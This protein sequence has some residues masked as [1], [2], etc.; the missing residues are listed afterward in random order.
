[1]AR[2]DDLNVPPPSIP[3][4]WTDDNTILEGNG[5][6]SSLNST[7]THPNAITTSSPIASL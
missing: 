4:L 6:S 3:E 1:M 7:M 5:S 2:H